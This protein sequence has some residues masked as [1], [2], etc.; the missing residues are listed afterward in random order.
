CSASTT[1]PTTI[2]GCDLRRCLGPILSITILSDWFV[3]FHANFAAYLNITESIVS[4]HGQN[5]DNAGYLNP[6]WSL[7]RI[8]AR[9]VLASLGLPDQQ[10][11]ALV[12]SRGQSMVEVR[13]RI[14][15]RDQDHARP[16]SQ[17]TQDHGRP[18]GPEDHETTGSD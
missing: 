6:N 5:T 12:R 8:G 2:A 18:R 11:H 4:P 7:Y 3:K 17:T 13:P 15:P 14:R 9:H 1:G 10:V 16:R